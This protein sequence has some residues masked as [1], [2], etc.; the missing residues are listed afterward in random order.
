MNSI[1]QKDDFF[2]ALNGNQGPFLKG[3]TPFSLQQRNFK[4]IEHDFS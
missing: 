3:L 1:N 2:L 4:N